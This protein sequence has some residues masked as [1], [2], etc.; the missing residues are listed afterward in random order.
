MPFLGAVCLFCRGWHV[1]PA[2]PRWTPFTDGTLRCDRCATGAVET[3]HDAR[4]YLPTVRR[5]LTGLGLSLPERVPVRMVAADEGVVALGRPG[6]GV[7]LGFTEQVVHGR[8]RPR[9]TGISIVA[10]MPPIFFGRAVAH[11][12]GHAWLALHGEAPVDDVTEEGLCE[13]FAYAWLRRDGT[14]TAHRLRRELRTNPD[15]LYGGGFRALHAV[16]Q[17]DGVTT[18]LDR[19]LRTG[20]PTTR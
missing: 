7:L 8:G 17:R 14:P 6:P 15:P 2:P 1:N 12:F 5:H 19:L 4:R 11:E 10:G 9:V 13:L 18:V 3:Q 20:R 16:V